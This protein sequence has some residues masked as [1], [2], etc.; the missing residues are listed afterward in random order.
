[1]KYINTFI[2]LVISQSENN[3]SE[4]VFKTQ[5]KRKTNFFFSSQLTVHVTAN[6]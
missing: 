4:E 2:H 6:A 1:M 3:L 5:S